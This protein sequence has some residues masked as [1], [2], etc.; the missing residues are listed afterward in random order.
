MRIAD[1]D[2]QV[3]AHQAGPVAHAFHFEHSGEATLTPVTM[4]FNSERLS[5]WSA[6]CIL[7]SLGRFT[8]TSVFDLNGDFR[9]ELL[10]QLTLRPLH[11]HQVTLAH[12]NAD[13]LRQ[14][15]R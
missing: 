3:L 8:C 15:D 7:A 14:R 13:A 2:D 12:R 5:P 11:S 10:L 4:L 1:H 6:L 9:G